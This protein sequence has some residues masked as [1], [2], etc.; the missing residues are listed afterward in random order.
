MKL[1]RIKGAKY[2]S[3]IDCNKGFYTIKLCANS[4]HLTC[5]ISP[6][7][8]YVFKRL[9]FGISCA[10]E[11]F[12]TKFSQILINVPNVLVHIDDILVYGETKEIHD[13]T[14]MLVL[15]RLSLEGITINKEKSEFGVSEVTYLGNVLSE[16]GISTD[17][18]RAEAILKFPRPRSKVEVQRFLVMINFLA[19]FIW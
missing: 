11:Y 19:R 10:P 4:R 2:F 18:K 3:K 5:F 14:L 17:P 12:V 7:G 13:K 9:P 16:K 1:A 15:E 8:R 6:F